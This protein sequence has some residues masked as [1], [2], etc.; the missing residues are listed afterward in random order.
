M[1]KFLNTTEISAD[2]LGQIYKNIFGWPFY[3]KDCDKNGSVLTFNIPRSTPPLSGIKS[4]YLF[5]R[6][7]AYLLGLCEQ[8]IHKI[9][10]LSSAKLVGFVGKF[11]RP[12]KHAM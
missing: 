7:L 3:C 1:D 10:P 4:S 2:I 8:N 5:G 9:W 6:L 11:V 12:E